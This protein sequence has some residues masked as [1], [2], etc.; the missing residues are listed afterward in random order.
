MCNVE[1]VI[2]WEKWVTEGSCMNY[3][4]WKL[5]INLSFLFKLLVLSIINHFNKKHFSP[6]FTA[7]TICTLAFRI[8]LTNKVSI[9]A[10][11]LIYS[12]INCLSLYSGGTFIKSNSSLSSPLLSPSSP[13]C[14]IA[15]KQTFCTQRR[16]NKGSKTEIPYLMIVEDFG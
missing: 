7:T 2:K 11:Q 13:C 5:N 1:C 10:F 6:M 14:L 3:I 4:N 15:W 16:I 12:C 8:V 9:K